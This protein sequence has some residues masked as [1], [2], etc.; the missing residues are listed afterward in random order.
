MSR[1]WRVGDQTAAATRVSAPAGICHLWLFGPRRGPRGRERTQLQVSG[2]ARAAPRAAARLQA[3]PW[4]TAERPWKFPW[5]RRRPCLGN[6]TSGCEAGGVVLAQL[7]SAV[8]QVLGCGCGSLAVDQGLTRHRSAHSTPQ[9]AA[10][11]LPCL[12]EAQTHAAKTPRSRSKPSCTHTTTPARSTTTGTP[13]AAGT[14]GPTP[15][16]QPQVKRRKLPQRSRA[17]GCLC[18]DA[19][20]G[21]GCGRQFTWGPQAG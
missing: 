8:I 19:A 15:S 20:L 12:D 11:G 17:P 5:A 3:C 6:L 9:Q 14:G 13:L 16:A 7:S 2:E 4:R 1:S 18:A 21:D 10:W